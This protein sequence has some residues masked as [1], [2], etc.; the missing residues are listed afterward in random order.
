[1]QL[2]CTNSSY[3][4]VHGVAGITS[5]YIAF[6]T[7]NCHLSTWL[8]AEGWFP[9]TLYAQTQPCCCHPHFLVVA[10][11]AAGLA[12]VVLALGC[13]HKQSLHVYR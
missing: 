2:L 1:V 10:V 9:S 6:G 8:S 5:H 4:A 12:V 3:M 7:T 13:K 11:A